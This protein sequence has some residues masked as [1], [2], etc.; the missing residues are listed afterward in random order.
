MTSIERS[1]DKTHVAVGYS[2][3]DIRIFDYIKQTV[4]ASFR[5]HR[6][7]IASL[8]FDISENSALLASGGKDSDILV[9]D[10]VALTGLSRLRGHKD[11]VTGVRFIHR[12]SQRL[13]LS[14]SKDTLLKVWDLSTQHCIQTIV[15]HRNEIWSMATCPV[16]GNVLV[17]TGSADGLLRGYCLSED[18][19]SD[20]VHLSDEE[21]V[22]EYIGSVE[23]QFA[24][25]KVTQL[26]F[27]PD[28][29]L[30]VAQNS[31]KNVE[32]SEMSYHRLF[33]DILF[34]CLSFAMTR[35]RRRSL[36]GG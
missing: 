34:S 8:A 31:G 18:N 28:S 32:V 5:G 26:Q 35:E 25:D 36:R 23:R 6:S 9:W 17:V 3:G 4:V 30:L 7:A 2:T 19:D 29:T 20:R 24:N 16:R 11:V 33:I 13:L 14:V 21:T 22:L 1:S 15:G 10:M 12:A 27:N